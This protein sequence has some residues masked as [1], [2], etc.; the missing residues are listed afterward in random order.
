MPLTFAHPAAVL[1]LMRGPLLPAAL[2]AGALAPDL[3]YFLRGL[4]VPVTAQSWWEPFVNATTTH[5]WPGAATIGLSTALLMF[6]VINVCARPARWM[7]APTSPTSPISRTPSRGAAWWGWLVLSLILGV[8]THVVWDSFTHSDGW[9]VQNVGFLNEDAAGSL[10]WARLVQH[11]STALGL[12]AVAVHVWRR[13]ERWVPATGEGRRLPLRVVIV[14][15]LAAG[16]G[17][18]AVVVAR[19]GLA[20]GAEHVL[21]SAAVGAGLGAAVVAV[22]LSLLWWIVRPDEDRRRTSS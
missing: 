7:V 21:S 17:A 18:V 16:V 6:L 5:G 22:A 8:V 2:V 3:P 20:S 9:V 19:G 10:T 12:A 4:Q 14:G 1:P 15:L 13:R 11:L